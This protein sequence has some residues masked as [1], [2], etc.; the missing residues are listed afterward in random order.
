VTSTRGRTVLTA[1]GAA[2]ALGGCLNSN[3]PAESPAM[4]ARANSPAVGFYR[5]VFDPFQSLSRPAMERSAVPWKVMAAAMLGL[6]ATRGPA[7]A[8]TEDAYVRL[9]ERRYG[10]VVP[11][12]VANWPAWEHEPAFNRPLGI[13]SG[14][15]GHAI[16][17]IEIEVANLGCATC[18]S[19][20]LYDAAGNPTRDAWVGLPSSSIDLGRYAEDA[21]AALSRA[22]DRPEE[23]L[24]LARQ[25]FPAMSVVEEDSLRRF[26]FPELAAR[27]AELR[28]TIGAFTPYSNGGP[29][30]TNGVATLKL[31]LGALDAH[32]PAPGEVAFTSVP[33]L[34]PLRVRTSILWDGIYAAPGWAHAGVVEPRDRPLP[35][36]ARRDGLAGIVSIVTIG[37]LGVTPE[38]AATNIPLVAD[39][40]EWMLTSYRPP[41]FPG[42][43]D[44]PLAA[45]GGALFERHCA[46]CHGSYEETPEGLR[47]V[48]FPNKLVPA[49]LIE[50]DPTRARAVGR[51]PNALFA[52]TALG[53]HVDARATGGYIAPALTALWATAPYLHNGSVPTLWHLMRP[54]ARPTRFQVGGHRLDFARVGLDEVPGADGVSR[55][56]AGYQPWMEPEI[57]DTRAPGRSNAGHDEPF[58]S[59]GEDDKRALLEFLKRV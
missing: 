52:G 27:I 12:R 11:A 7:P 56:P 5:F 1:L 9:L 8:L 35:L 31:Y 23:T 28:G 42:P 47:V 55:Y 32:R 57:Y 40:V 51:D 41:P 19:A 36:A 38:V 30:L 4:A 22:A 15:L 33:D 37:T 34:A 46:R 24:A 58:S 53:P 25:V 13:V 10:F 44:A 3:T 6:E 49:Y 2:L 59:L 39:A 18:H 43:I 45:R 20:R 48:R 16:P 29:G 54:E 17:H 50:T 26:Y 14:T 21:F